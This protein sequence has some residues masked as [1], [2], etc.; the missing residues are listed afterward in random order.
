MSRA[1]ESSKRRKKMKQQKWLIG[2]VVLGM[3]VGLA[4]IAG[5]QPGVGGGPGG[6]GA[7][8]GNRPDFRNMTP[9]QR[10]Q[11]F[12]QQQQQRR[13]DWIR[14]A[15][16]ASGF[17]DKTVQDAVTA[18]MAAQDKT[19]GPLQEQAHELSALLIDPNATNE[20]L[21]T[22]LAD[23]RQAVAN[24][25]ARHA[26][27]LAALDTQI[28]Y[29]T[30]PRLETL[31]TLLGVVGY[32]IP[33]IGGVGAVFPDSPYGNRGGFGGRG[34]QGGGQGGPGGGQGGAPGGQGGRG[35]R[36][37][38]GGAPGGPGRPGGNAPQQ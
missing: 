3:T 36:G 25:K 22:T 12:Q 33:Q 15:M 5:A 31:L 34:G 24:D 27:E 35:G 11:F 29:S 37:G 10:Q 7:A 30:Q 20:Q 14:Q 28:K 1:N 18:F 6:G 8:G 23:F 21:K 4:G 38:Q 13:E 19:S 17:T 26:T 9:E 2:P 16:A 32:E